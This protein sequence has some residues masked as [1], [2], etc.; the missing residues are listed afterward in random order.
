[1]KK[2]FAILMTVS[3]TY[4]ASSQS[5]TFPIASTLTTIDGETINSN[6]FKHD[7]PIIIDFWATYCKP[8]II[9]Y[10]TL[11][12][13]YA[14]WQKRTGVKIISI[15]I[16]PAS[17]VESAKKFVEAFEWP[18]EMYFD[19]DSELISKLNNGSK[20]VPLT[21]IYDKDFNLVHKST[22]ASVLYEGSAKKGVKHL[23]SGKKE[24][25]DFTVDLSK[26]FEIIDQII[27]K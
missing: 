17:R 9:K 18:Y 20:V 3:I 25:T 22:G 1:M 13:K 27:S 8:C 16:D 11:K 23:Y 6:T 15:S 4:F 19:L 12:D 21:L 5:K 2:I 10:N 26:Y 24:I 7:G 14:E